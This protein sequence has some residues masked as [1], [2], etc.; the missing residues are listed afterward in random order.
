[1]PQILIKVHH[2]FMWYLHENF[3]RYSKWK[4]DD[5]VDKKEN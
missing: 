4:D 5:I 3:H 2:W 1:M